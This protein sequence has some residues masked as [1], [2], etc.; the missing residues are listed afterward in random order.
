MKIAKT[1]TMVG[2]QHETQRWGVILAG[3]DG[4]R[5][6]SLT[7]SVSDDN[8]PK[9]FCPLLG[10]KTLLAETR[11][12]VQ[13]NIDSSR[14]LFLLTK[15]HEPFYAGELENVPPDRMI[16][17]PSNR[18]TL[19]AILWSLLRIARQDEHASVVFFPSDHYY[20]HEEKFV[21]GVKSALD[22]ADADP[23]A[24]MLLGA[25][26]T[27]PEVEYGWI[28]PERN[29]AGRSD[30]GLMQVKRFWEK[31]AYQTAERLLVEGCLWNTFVMV[32]RASAFLE[33]I[34]QAVPDLYRSFKAALAVPDASREA[35]VMQSIYDKLSGA[36]FSSEVLSVSTKHLTVTSLGDIGWSDLGD[37][38]RLITTLFKSGIDNPWVASGSCSFCG[39]TL[40][41][42]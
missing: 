13:A 28:E 42:P 18:G 31:P 11:H 21:E 10:G 32:G 5:L 35:V 12:R 30:S 38:H 3:G 22:A 16:V 37:P 36:D 25:A 1:P 4:A 29:T 26:P 15:K 33:M 23:C 9:Q 8:R 19:P 2:I 7:R 20:S 39:E 6:K 40:S 14:I 24:V 41:A 17:Q 27:Q 34:R